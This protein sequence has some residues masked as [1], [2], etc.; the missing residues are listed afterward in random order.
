VIGQT[1]EELEGRRWPE[2]GYASGLVM[3]VHRL[4][5]KPIT[6]FSVEDLR[7]MIGQGVGLPHLVPHGVELLEQEPLAEGDFYPGDLLAAV[8]GQREWLA[9]YPKLAGRVAAVVRKALAGPSEIDPIVRQSL[10]R[11]LDERR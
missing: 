3:T 5:A 10:E 9:G 4:R 6:D 2:P 1:L 7:I 11:F 8:V